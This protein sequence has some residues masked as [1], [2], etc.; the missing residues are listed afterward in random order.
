MTNALRIRPIQNHRKQMR[1]ECLTKR[2]SLRKPHAANATHY[3]P[4]AKIEIPTD[5]K[6]N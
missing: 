2:S 3:I 5:S 1:R 6:L 4:R